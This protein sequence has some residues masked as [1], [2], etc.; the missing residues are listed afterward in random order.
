MRLILIQELFCADFENI[1]RPGLSNSR[2]NN[3]FIVEPT[4]S[5]CT[6][7]PKWTCGRAAWSCTRFSAE[8]FPSTTNTCLLYSGKSNVG[9]KISENLEKLIFPFYE[10]AILIIIILA[11]KIF[12]I[13]LD[14]KKIILQPASSRF[15]TIWKPRSWVFWLKCSRSIPW[16]EPP[17]RM[18][19][20]YF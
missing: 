2:R 1:I 19:C 14:V 10:I 8:R 7:A 5:D 13:L 20:E 18:L 12:W 16:K 9:F 3:Y 17:S 11:I 15:Q 4:F 6:P